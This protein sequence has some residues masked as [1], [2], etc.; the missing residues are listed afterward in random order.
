METTTQSEVAQHDAH[1]Q[2]EA[3]GSQHFLTQYVFSSD[4]K[5]IGIQYGV[6][7]LFF[8]MVGFL[9]IMAMR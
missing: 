4:H 6:T 5:V 2:H 3:H 9:L 1:E 8:L 7:S